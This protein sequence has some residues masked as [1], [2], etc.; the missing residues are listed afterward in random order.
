VETVYVTGHTNPDMDCTV[1]SFAYAYLKNKLRPGSRYEAIRTGALN[2]QTRL[3]FEKAE[4]TPPPLVKSLAPVVGDITKSEY[5]ALSPEAPILE[6][7]RVIYSRNIS[8]LPLID[9]EHFV[10]SV[11]VNEVSAYIVSMSHAGRPSYRFSVDNFSDVLPGV[12]LST[13]PQRNFEAPIMT[14]AMPFDVYR[15]RIEGLDAKPLLIVGNR[16]DILEHAAGLDLPALVITGL[17]DPDELAIDLEGYG[18][19]VYASGADTAESIRLLRLSVPVG[20]IA[21][22]DIPKV[23]WNESFEDAKRKLIGSEHRGLPVFEGDVF[24]GI[25]T[26]RSFIEKPRKKLILVDHNE[27]HQSVRGAEDADIVEIIDHHRFAAGKTNRPIYISSKPVGSTSTIVYQHYKMHEVYLPRDVAILLLSGVLSDTVNLKSPTA[28]EEDVAAIRELSTVTGLDPGEYAKEMFSQLKALRERAP[29]EVAL[30][31]FKT[32]SQ[33]GRKVGIGQVEVITLEETGDLVPAF[34]DA[35]SEVAREKALDWTMLLVTDVLKTESLLISTGFAGGRRP[36]SLPTPRRRGLLPPRHPE[37][38]EAGA[39]GG[40]AGAGGLA[41]LVPR[42]YT[43]R[44]RP[45]GYTMTKVCQWLEGIEG[46][47]AEMYSRLATRFPRDPRL[48]EFLTRLAEDENAHHRFIRDA[49]GCFDEDGVLVDEEVNLDPAVVRDVEYAFVLV[50]SL[51][52]AES[53][54]LPTLFTIIASIE[55]SEWN[56]YFVYV[57]QRVT[58]SRRDFEEM[59]AEIQAHEDRIEDFLKNR[60]E[61]QAALDRLRALKKIWRRHVLLA[62]DDG[63]TRMFEKSLLSRFG[64]VDE[65]KNGKMALELASKN[66]YDLIVSDIDMPEMTGLEFLRLYRE[67]APEFGGHVVFVSGN[68]DLRSEATKLGADFVSK[69][70]LPTL[71]LATVEQRLSAQ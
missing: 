30:A 54:P 44:K 7:M 14:G 70:I 42:T 15:K 59:A 47:A 58:E 67:S 9:R 20:T 66:R 51:L 4:I 26:R 64:Q 65:A 69:P 38:K 71:L 33:F 52:E 48:T 3:A 50:D 6:A 10:G 45:Q 25:V 13:G 11:S 39:A 16:K 60:P 61:G 41:R 40:A 23:Q 28:T 27:V 35:L 24:R 8:M 1:A 57:V 18:G 63:V 68:D 31:D 17:D 46:R 62:E 43:D 55:T 5:V 37:S 53:I 21:N 2:T 12:F 29:K 56:E 36:A 34:K 32:Y 19:T 22:T 49:E